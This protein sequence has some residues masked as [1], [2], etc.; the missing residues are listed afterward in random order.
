MYKPGDKVV[1]RKDLKAGKVYGK[2][3]WFPEMGCLLD[4]PYVTISHIIS[5]GYYGVEDMI[6]KVTDEMISHKYKE[7]ERI[8]KYRK[9]DKVVLREDLVYGEL[10]GACYWT[11]W[12]KPTTDQGYVTITEVSDKYY[13]I[14]DSIHAYTDEMISHKYEEERYVWYFEERGETYFL[15]KK[16]LIKASSRKHLRKLLNGEVDGTLITEEEAKQSTF[17]HFGI[18]NKHTPPPKEQLYYVCIP[19][20]TG[21]LYMNYLISEDVYYA[22]SIIEDNYHRTKFTEEEADK[23]IGTSTVLYKKEVE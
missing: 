16:A 8:M 20:S 14:K 10:Y 7:P 17:F 15:T 3:G 22:G 5:E 4:P 13:R 19:T 21:N 2:D 18:L 12:M 6:Y 11:S 9:G 1:L 23:I